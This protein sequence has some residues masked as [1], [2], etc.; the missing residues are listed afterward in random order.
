MKKL[1]NYAATAAIAATALTVA[2]A[3]AN[4]GV[5]AEIVV[6]CAATVAGAAICIP[7][8]FLLHELAVAGN[9]GEAFGPNGEVM[10]LLAVPVEI[11]SGNFDAAGREAN[12]V[13]ALIRGTTGISLRD[14]EAYGLPGGPNSEVRRFGRGI[15]DIFGW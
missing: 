2:P 13:T 5:E 9:G 12:P 7:L 14:I 8:G 3:E 10:R 11:V 15:A 4:A 6:E 1:S